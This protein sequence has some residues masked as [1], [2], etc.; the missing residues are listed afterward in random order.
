MNFLP[1]FLILEMHECSSA[2]DCTPGKSC[3]VF[4]T[5]LKVIENTFATKQILH[6]SF[7]NLEI[8]NFISMFQGRPI[9]ICNEGDEEV[10]SH[11]FRTLEVPKTVD[12]LQGIV[13]VIPLQLL[14]FHIAVLRGYDVS[15]YLVLHCLF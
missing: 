14:S 13:S 4:T 12:C 3:T 10:K 8:H 11:A 2:G 9:I 15:V 1:T 5:L 6:V 7:L